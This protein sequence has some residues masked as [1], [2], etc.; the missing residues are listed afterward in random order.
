MVRLRSTNADE[1][2]TLHP[3]GIPARSVPRSAAT[4]MVC[5][6][7]SGVVEV[8]SSPPVRVRMRTSAWSGVYA[9]AC[10]WRARGVW[11]RAVSPSDPDRSA[12]RVNTPIERPRSW[13]APKFRHVPAMRTYYVHDLSSAYVLGW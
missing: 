4:T 10:A 1:S 7:R 12:K 3:Y 5:I 6:A 2:K 9:C 11:V 13:C 8:L